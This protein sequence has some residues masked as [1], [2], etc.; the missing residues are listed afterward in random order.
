MYPPKI[1]PNE[2][3]YRHLFHK[4]RA[5]VGKRLENARKLT[6]IIDEICTEKST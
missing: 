6:E 3:N 5:F 2:T 1:P 4:L